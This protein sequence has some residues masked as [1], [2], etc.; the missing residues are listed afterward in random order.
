MAQ[1][2]YFTLFLIENA[3]VYFRKVYINDNFVKTLSAILH[4]FQLLFPKNRRFKADGPIREI[5]SVLI[6]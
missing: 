2:E 6:D 5:Y 4:T 3:Y 1:L